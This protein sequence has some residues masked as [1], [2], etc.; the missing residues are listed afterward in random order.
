MERQIDY[1]IH[2][3]FSGDSNEKM[4]NYVKKA[5]NLG[6]EEIAFTEHFESDPQEIADYGVPALRLLVK[7]IDRLQLLYPSVKLRYG[8]EIG[9]YHRNQDFAD[10]IKCKYPPDLKIGSIHAMP[11]GYNVSVPLKF[12]LTE[13]ELKLYYEE[14]IYL[15]ES[16]KVDI[17]GHLGIYARFL[18]NWPDLA[19]CKR[20]LEK[21]IDLLI[22]TETALEI[23]TSGLRNTIDSLIPDPNVILM[24]LKKGGK[25]ITLGSDSHKEND[26]DKVYNRATGILKD[27]GVNEITVKENNRWNF[28]KI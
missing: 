18:E 21:I 4:E 17:L 12:K 2:T 25:L 19:S 13:K 5:V 16:V 23:N 20:H 10:S 15:L 9:E 6:Y 1:H 8:L 24:Y 28:K 11:G 3:D 26:F 14:N 22:K 7:E 27:C